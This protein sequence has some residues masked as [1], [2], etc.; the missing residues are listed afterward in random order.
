MSNSND[1]DVLRA[2][3]ETRLRSL[4]SYGV[5]GSGAE[6]TFDAVTR[7]AALALSAP[8]AF[9]TIVGRERAWHKASFGADPMSLPVEESLCSAVVSSGAPVIIS[10]LASAPEWREHPQAALGVRAYAGIPLIGRDGMALGALCVADTM[11]RDFTS[12]QLEVL[13]GLTEVAAEL[14]E[15]RRVDQQLF[16][17]RGLGQDADHVLKRGRDV[18]RALEMGEFVVL[19]QPIV[20]L[21]GG[22]VTEVEALVRWEVPGLGLLGPQSFLP[23]IESSEVLSEALRDFVL[24]RAL[25]DLS[26]WHGAGAHQLRVSVNISGSA[27]RAGGLSEPVLD[28]LQRHG[29]PAES[30]T[31]ELTETASLGD[32]TRAATELAAVRSTGVRLALDDFGIGYNGLE[33]TGLLPFDIMKLDRGFVAPVCERGPMSVILRSTV[34]LARQLGLDVIAEGIEREDQALALVDLGVRQ[35]QGFYFSRPVPFEQIVTLLELPSLGTCEGELR[36]SPVPE[37]RACSDSAGYAA[38]ISTIL[39]M[40]AAGASAHTIAAA[41]NQRALPRPGGLRWHSAVVA[42]IIG[43]GG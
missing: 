11:P 7:S 18:L 2:Q 28:A 14:L 23:Y 27:V 21:P 36:T 24:D 34:A 33:L 37:P 35:G 6:R 13:D 22:R 8:R 3:E 16:G 4:S 38:A 41:L 25:R 15:L 20:D 31:L 40:H 9:L 19:Y 17:G 1:G 26:R 43:P 30:L 12:E 32:L 5:S 39:H 29:V 10:D 42:R